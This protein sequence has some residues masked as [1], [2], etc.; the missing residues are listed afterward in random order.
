MG[1]VIVVHQ[2]YRLLVEMRVVGVMV[3]MVMVMMGMYDHYHLRLCRK[4]HCETEDENQSKQDLF[5]TSVWR[6]SSRDTELL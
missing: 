5:H 6:P 1:I 4:R 2:I 3:M